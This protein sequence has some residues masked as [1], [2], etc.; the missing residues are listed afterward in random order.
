MDPRRWMPAV[1]FIICLF[2][3]AALGSIKPAA[4]NNMR[5]P[6]SLK[7][8]KLPQKPIGLRIS[9]EASTARVII[10]FKENTDVLLLDG[11]LVG[12]NGVSLE[13]VNIIL[14][15][16][17]GKRIEKLFPMPDEELR[18]AKSRLEGVSRQ[19]LADL[20]LY[21]KLDITDNVEAENV[22]NRLNEL[23]LVEIAYPDPKAEPAV[24]IDPPTP[25]ME[26]YQSYL[27]DAPAGIDAAYA[28]GLP[29]GDGSGVTII[30][31]ENNW[32]EAHEDLEKA[33]GGTIGPGNSPD[34][35]HGTAV[36]GEMISG[37]NGYGV[38]GICPGAEVAMV[39]AYYYGTAEAIMLAAENLDR[40]DVMLIE[41][42]APG[43]RYDFQVRPDQ[44]GYVCME[45]W[46]DRFDAIQYAW[47]KGIIVVE[48]AGNGAENFDYPLYGQLFDT[49]YRN[50]HAII[51][52]AGAPPSGNYGLDRSRLGFSNYGQR[53]NLQGYGREVY[54]TGYGDYWNGDGDVNQYYTASFS[55]TSSASPIVAGA[56][57]CL[58]GYYEASYG[59]PLTSDLARDV[60][61][62]TGSPQ[63]GATGE[64][65]GPRPDLEAAIAALTSPPSFST[66]P[67]FIDTTLEEGSAASV[68][69][70][71]YNRSSGYALDFY[72]EG[73]DSLLKSSPPDWLKISP[74][75][76]TVSPLDSFSLTITID[77]T[78]IGDRLTPYK[79]II[80]IAWGIAGGSLDSSACIP[81]FLTVPCVPDTTFEVASS[82]SPEGP[83]YNW[84]DIT[85]I[86]TMIPQESYYNGQA[87]SPLDDGTAGPFSLPFEFPFYDSTYSQFYVGVNGGIS[88]TDENVN[89][90]GYYGN[91]PIPGAPFS[92][93]VAIF[94]NDL[95][96]GTAHAAHGDI[97]YYFSPTDD[98]AIVEWYQ[99]GNYNSLY[100]TMTTF[101][102]I[103]TADGDITMQYENVGYTG[104]ENTALIGLCAVE[105]TATP[106]CRNASPPEN[107]VTGMTAVRF[108]RQPLQIMAGDANGDK[109]INI[110]D[111]TYL[112]NYVY[113]GGPPPEPLAS[114]DPNCNSAINILDITFLIN[115]LYKGG[116]APCYYTEP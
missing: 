71:V 61:Y 69:L 105:C 94:W 75:T 22:I 3:S 49:T 43:P 48:A 55:G 51:C 8:R 58:Q 53:V 31:V 23:D 1:I 108:E 25:D 6:L 116:P 85:G 115:Y 82:V 103:F 101:Q 114:G 36:L 65:I 54:T 45:Y 64:H 67:I 78:V 40:G 38:T 26:A 34:G 79:G 50:S 77:A 109:T 33:V 35:D 47:A 17:L 88:F 87:G 2:D 30:D 102:V 113:R 13:K 111:I 44:L 14:Q 100:D 12:E 32:N 107:V 84:I 95:V 80:E 24:D 96:M 21:Y 97:Y 59:I 93:F 52:G 15:P 66:E 74:P 19:E 42:H 98:S 81:V 9:P 73:T 99:I 91:P 90:N 56:V 29:G 27:F 57:T 20:N 10:K 5:A 63:Q 46:Q 62:S 4:Y 39:S 16:Y 112:I 11:K 89:I 41:L 28:H 72:A 7:E 92:T 86:G 70:W 18:L 104:L 106:Y 60:L 76:G 68:P 110:L 37:D 83:Q